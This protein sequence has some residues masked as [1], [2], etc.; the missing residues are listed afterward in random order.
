MVVDEG[1][2]GLTGGTPEPNA[3]FA[4]VYPTGTMARF[5]AFRALAMAFAFLVCLRVMHKVMMSARSRRN[6]MP[7]ITLAIIM[8]RVTLPAEAWDSDICEADGVAVDDAEDVN[9]GVVV[10]IAID[11]SAEVGVAIEVVIKLS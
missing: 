11:P 6:A 3:W 4:P 1:R 10:S 5:E 8:V 7:P 9:V 2:R